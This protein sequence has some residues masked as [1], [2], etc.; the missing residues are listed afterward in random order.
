[1]FEKTLFVAATASLEDL[2]IRAGRTTEPHSHFGAESSPDTESSIGFK[3]PSCLG[4]TKYL[5]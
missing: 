5:E 2:H 3:P 1:M 4:G